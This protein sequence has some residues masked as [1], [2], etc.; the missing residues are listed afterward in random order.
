MRS[1]LCKEVQG[2]SNILAEKI[3]SDC[4]PA[5]EVAARRTWV[6]GGNIGLSQGSKTSEEDAS[7]L[8]VS[9]RVFPTQT[10]TCCSKKIVKSCLR[11]EQ[12]KLVPLFA[13]FHLC[14]LRSQDRIP[15]L[16]TGT[17]KKLGLDFPDVFFGVGVSCFEVW[18]P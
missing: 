18:S 15:K 16:T 2:P 3:D 5:C 11:V 7:D 10:A 17:F 13:P 1:F 12:N 4:C 14:C 9:T 6:D 8:L